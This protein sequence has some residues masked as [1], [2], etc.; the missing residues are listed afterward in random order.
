VKNKKWVESLELKEKEE[1][2]VFS[3]HIKFTELLQPNL[4]I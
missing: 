4:E 2:R 1:Q 3:E